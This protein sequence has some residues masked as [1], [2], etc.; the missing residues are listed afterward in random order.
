MTDFIGL[1]AIPI[2]GWTINKVIQHS[3]RIAVLEQVALDIRNSLKR[4]E[5]HFYAES[6]ARRHTEDPGDRRRRS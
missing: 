4:L 2:A 3:N 6:Q 5:E 1:A